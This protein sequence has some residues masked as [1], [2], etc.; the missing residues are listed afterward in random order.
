MVIQAVRITLKTLSTAIDRIKLASAFF[1]TIPGP[2][3]IWQFGELR[4]DYSI[5]FNGRTGN[6]PIRWD[7]YSDLKD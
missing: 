5:N 1:F 3:M 7:Y 6:K 2:K 4:Y